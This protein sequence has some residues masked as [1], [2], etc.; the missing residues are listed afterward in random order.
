MLS[1][2]E[3]IRRVALEVRPGDYVNL[4]IGMPTLVANYIPEDADVILQSENGLLG[5]GPFPLDRD[6]DPDLINAGKQTVTYTKGASFFSSAD[7]FAMI[8]GGHV[9]LTILGAMEVSEKGDLANWMIP[10]K[11]V[12][13]MGGAMD[14]VAGAKKVIVVMEH[15]NKEGV[16][17]FL[18]EC[19]LPL[20]GKACV[21][22][23]VTEMGVFEFRNGKFV[24]TEISGKISL[25]Q[26]KA[27]T[28]ADY[29]VD[30]NLK[31]I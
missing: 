15:V 6:V 12:K 18:K 2:E 4:G 30:K 7:S 26:L 29:E 10:G 8:R 5:I 11:M 28:E 19:R 27:K 1:K 24:L 23:L 17:K 21:H 20:T 31:K 16:P 25:E 22:M 3:M 14:L 13:G 9:D